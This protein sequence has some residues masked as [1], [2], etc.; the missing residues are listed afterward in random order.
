MFMSGGMP[1]VKIVLRNPLNYKDT[2]DYHIK[3]Y[4]NQ[5]SRD[6]I[7]ALKELLQSGNLLEKNSFCSSS[8]FSIRRLNLPLQ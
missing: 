2:V 7:V 4:N 6:W 3:P 5:L 1:L 8:R